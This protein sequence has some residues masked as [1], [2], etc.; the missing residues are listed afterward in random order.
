MPGSENLITVKFFYVY[1]LKSLKN[2]NLYIGY[3]NNLKKRIKEHN[4][5]LVF[6]SKPYIP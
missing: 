4:R 2:K 1:V 3:T 6:S 5:G